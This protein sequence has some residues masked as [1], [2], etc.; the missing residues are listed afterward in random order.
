[1][2]FPLTN[3]FFRIYTE[4]SL[5]DKFLSLGD[6][7]AATP[8]TIKVITPPNITDGTN[9]ITLAAVPDSNAPSSFDEPTKILLTEDTRP[10][11]S[12]EV[13]NWR[14]LPRTTT[15]TKSNDP[16]KNRQAAER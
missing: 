13:N 12:L 8:T 9:P 2:N 6:K 15:L 3:D 10:F 5:S 16:L 4:Q 7:P 14:M 1:M 11:I